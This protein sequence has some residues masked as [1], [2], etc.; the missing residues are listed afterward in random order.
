MARNLMFSPNIADMLQNFHWLPELKY[1]QIQ[2]GTLWYREMCP[3]YWT[4]IGY[5][6]WRIWWAETLLDLCIDLRKRVY[7][8]CIFM[9]YSRNQ[10]YTKEDKGFLRSFTYIFQWEF[11]PK[12]II[13]KTH[14][15]LVSLVNRQYKFPIILIIIST[16][17]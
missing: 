15:F 3:C 11:P 2:S 6:Y 12:L 8:L 16:K 5:L 17:I 4:V 9:G 14:I 13:F 7:D 1:Y 10:T